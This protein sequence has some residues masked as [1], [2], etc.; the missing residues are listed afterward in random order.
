ME[1][2]AWTPGCFCPLLIMLATPP[3]TDL[4]VSEDL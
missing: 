4:S 2:D 3:A 1:G